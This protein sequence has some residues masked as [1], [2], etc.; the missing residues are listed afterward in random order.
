MQMFHLYFYFS[1][2]YQKIVL[3]LLF[4]AAGLK[5]DV[6][7]IL[8]N[9]AQKMHSLHLVFVCLFFYRPS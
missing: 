1:E 7:Q 4:D 9:F 3:F 6:L 5:S 2:T 8:Q